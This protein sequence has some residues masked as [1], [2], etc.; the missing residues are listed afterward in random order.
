MRGDEKNSPLPI[1]DDPSSHLFDYNYLT[2]LNL[3]EPLLMYMSINQSNSCVPTCIF[4]F[5]FMKF[6]HRQCTG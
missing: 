5:F 6:M 1:I 2:N 4:L 3:C